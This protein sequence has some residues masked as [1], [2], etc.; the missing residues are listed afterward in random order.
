MRTIALL[1]V[2]LGTLGGSVWAQYA[3]TAL[4][5]VFTPEQAERGR[6]LYDQHCADCHG[7]DLLGLEGPRAFPGA[8]AKTPALA[9]S[10]FAAR[11]GGMSADQLLERMRV[12]MP[13][14]NPGTLSRRMNVEILA[15]M[16]SQSGVQPGARELPADR[17]SLELISMPG[18]ACCP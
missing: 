5:G 4:N 18:A 12:S 14:Q 13:Q 16:L 11:W 8:P 17:D 10:E 6:A 9:G 7:I 1:V 3:G 2:A 15:Y